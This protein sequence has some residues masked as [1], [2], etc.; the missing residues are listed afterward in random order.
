[1]LLK[2]WTRCKPRRRRS[3]P[4]RWSWCASPMSPISRR[5]PNSCVCCK[6]ALP[7]PTA[8]VRHRQHARRHRRRPR[9]ARS[10][11]ARCRLGPIRAIRRRRGR[12]PRRRRRWRSRPNRCRRVLPRSWHCST[13]GAEAVMRSHLV[14]HL[15]L[16]H[17]EPGRIEFRPAEGAPRDLANRL[18]QL[19][20]EWT[21]TRW[22]VAISDAEGEPTL[23][24]QEAAHERDLRN[25]VASHPLVQA[26]LATFPGATI[27]AV[28]ERFAASTAEPEE[29]LRAKHVRGRG[30]PR[31][32]RFMKNLGQLMKQAQAMQEKMAEMQAALEIVEMTGLA[33][34]GLVEVTLNGK[35]DVK[36]HQDRQIPAQPRGCRGAGRPYRRR[37]RRC[38]AQGSRSR[39]GRNAEADRR[40][41][42]AGGHETA[43]LTFCPNST[44]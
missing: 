32:G 6:T 1:M 15:H 34:G 18:A 24:Q 44:P 7:A 9:R 2:V 22:L 36:K 16:V 20:S 28:R 19:L 10:P 21:G 25:E 30:Q 14:S 40:A 4:R 3:R 31:R 27:A 39:R 13:S 42:A 41:P 43:V 5:R 37:V 12:L 23:R 38:A 17:F 8:Q 29:T 35:S 11:V 26:V 33:G